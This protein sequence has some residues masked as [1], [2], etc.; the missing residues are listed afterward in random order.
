MMK[1][2]FMQKYDDVEECGKLCK[3]VLHTKAV[4]KSHNN[5]NGWQGMKMYFSPVVNTELPIKM[6]VNALL[7]SAMAW[8]MSRRNLKSISM[9]LMRDY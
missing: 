2:R 5:K 3:S 1:E 8:K 9:A 4:L 6:E 7:K